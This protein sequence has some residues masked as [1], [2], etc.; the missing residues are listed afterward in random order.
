MGDE[1][2]FWSDRPEDAGARGE[3]EARED[4]GPSGGAPS[5]GT[6][7][8]ELV[9]PAAGSALV[10]FMTGGLPGLLEVLDA[11]EGASF[12]DDV[13][14]PEALRR[15]EAA[16]MG[17]EQAELEDR[18]PIDESWTV[19]ATQESPGDTLG[20]EDVVR[21]LESEGVDCG[22]DPYDPRDTVNFLPPN[23]GL[24][25]R[26]LFAIT[27]PE[28]QE[29]KARDVLYGTPPAGV[30]YAWSAPG[31]SADVRAAIAQ[32]GGAGFHPAQA[33]SPVTSADPGLSDNRRLEHL[34]GG[35]TPAGIAVAVVALALVAIMA[36]AFM[37]LRG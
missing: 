10:G 5:P 37:L 31:A 9:T 33:P 25:S 23:A 36:A 6:S 27:V 17:H 34:A 16:V 22:W 15:A 18:K 35:G 14:D 20:L 11:R 7:P 29:P 28:S 13:E 8:L 32:A 3:A 19:V 26:K 24:T 4:G 1:S 2:G 12:E 30:T 21:A